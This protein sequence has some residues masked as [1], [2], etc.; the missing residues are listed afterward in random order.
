[1][2]RMELHIGLANT[3]GFTVILK[4]SRRNMALPFLSNYQDKGSAQGEPFLKLVFNA[5]QD[6]TLISF[7]L[8]MLALL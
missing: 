5:A 8:H 4:L 7:I 6:T 2:E 1:M 3:I